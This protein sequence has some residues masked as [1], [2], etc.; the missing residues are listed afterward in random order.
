MNNNKI[1]INIINAVSRLTG[2]SYEE[3]KSK[4]RDRELVEAR[5]V[6]MYFLRKFTTLS[7]TN[8]GKKFGG[9]DHSTVL[10]G[11]TKAEDLIQFDKQFA[12]RINQMWGEVNLASNCYEI[13]HCQELI[14]FEI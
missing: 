4:K 6:S 13:Y 2:I 12:K 14:G 1:A 10:H 5:H 11:L 8:I 7:T 9:R 3:M